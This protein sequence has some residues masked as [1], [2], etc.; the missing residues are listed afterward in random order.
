MKSPALY[1]VAFFALIALGIAE[2][3]MGPVFWPTMAGALYVLVAG[4]FYACG[5]EGI[6]VA[7]IVTPILGGTA[8]GILLFA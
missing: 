4:M 3:G 8:W 1:L 7:M 2:H 5:K 6:A